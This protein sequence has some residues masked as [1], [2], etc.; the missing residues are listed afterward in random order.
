MKNFNRGFTLIE[1]LVVIAIIGLLSSVVLVSLNSVRV[2]A[3][4]TKRV[5]EMKSMVNAIEMARTSGI[6]P[7]SLYSPIS[8]LSGILVSTYISSI[9]VDPNPSALIGVTY[10]Y[11][12]LNTFTAGNYCHNDTD[13]N[14]YAIAFYT[15]NKIGNCPA[16]QGSWGASL[17]CITNEGISPAETGN[18]AG[19]HCTQH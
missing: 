18:V 4:D 11:C 2:R 16:R 15:E 19:L 12:N 7:P 1:L 10:Y 17:C 8:S 6:T 5:S 14:T 9:P 3:R 13:S